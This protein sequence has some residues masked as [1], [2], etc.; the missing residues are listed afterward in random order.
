MQGGET[1]PTDDYLDYASDAD[2]GAEDLDAKYSRMSSGVRTRWITPGPQRRARSES[3]YGKPGM[4]QPDD[5][6]SVQK[7]KRSGSCG[8][9]SDSC[10]ADYNNGFFEAAFSSRRMARSAQRSGVISPTERSEVS[11]LFSFISL[12]LS[13]NLLN[14]KFDN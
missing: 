13:K 12:T 11:T 10:V 6:I 8:Y 3:P 9:T 4:F 1:D 2:N 14:F 5:F 7:Q